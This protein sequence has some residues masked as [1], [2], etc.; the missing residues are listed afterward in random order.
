[1]SNDLV[2]SQIKGRDGSLLK[3][4]APD[5]KSLQ[6]K[7]NYA[8]SFTV[9]NIASVS[10]HTFQFQRAN[11]DYEEKTIA[12][13]RPPGAGFT[14]MLQDLYYA[15]TSGASL[16]ERPLGQFVVDIG[17]RGDNLVCGV[18][19]TDSNADDPVSI[20]VTAAVLFFN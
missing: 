11:G 12:V 20:E 15:F 13:S 8:N 1:M 3:F 10:S 17:M 5:G 6:T 16:T 2:A 4:A 7:E 14:V 18:R 19:L 9:S